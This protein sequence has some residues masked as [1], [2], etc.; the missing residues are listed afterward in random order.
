[1]SE[2]KMPVSEKIQN[3]K[4][5]DG[6][7]LKYRIWV[8]EIKP[9]ATICI[10]HGIGEH[11]GRY[12]N[13]ARKFCQKG[14]QVFALDYRGHGLSS[15][16]PG[17]ISS[18]SDLL[19]DV[20][21]F[22]NSIKT[23]LENIPLFIYGHSMGGNIVLNYL[24][25]RAQDFNGAII[26]S[27]W[28]GLVNQPYSITIKISKLVNKI[29]PSFTLSTGIKSTGLSSNQKNQEQ[30]D[31]DPLMHGKITVRTFI[32]LNNS[33]DE[34]MQSG[35]QIKIPSLFCHGEADLVTRHDYTQRLALTNPSNKKFISYPGAL[36]EL[37]NEPVACT[38]FTDITNWLFTNIGT[39]KISD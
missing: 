36:H 18:M 13:W 9:V 30:A 22:I 2:I 1:M 6:T 19:N 39:N 34:I 38:M 26:T 33:A 20:E 7:E 37:H 15:G 27:P 11:S 28:L 32:E 3:L 23:E 29:Y 17:H 10:I 14:I 21:I 16:K 35:K 4:S 12:N 25:N 24:L 8:P 31:K 5:F